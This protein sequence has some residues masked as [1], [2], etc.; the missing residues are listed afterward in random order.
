MGLGRS[1]LAL[2]VAAAIVGLV[3]FAHGEPS[4]SR[5]RSGTA[6]T[7]LRLSQA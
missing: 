2:V 6:G 3:A 7:E 5:V 4:H 1:I